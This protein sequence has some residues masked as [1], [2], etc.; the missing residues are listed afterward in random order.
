MESSARSRAGEIGEDILIILITAAQLIFLTYFHRYISWPITGPGGSVT[1]LSMLTEGYFTWLPFPITASILVI[2][3]CI[4]MIVT[5]SYWFRQAAW[6]VFCIIGVTVTVSLLLIFPFDFSVIPNAA[7]V[8]IVPTAV[9][10]FLILWA[11]M[12][13]V[14]GSVLFVRLRRDR[15]K[16]ESG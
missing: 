6:V 13:A 1:R 8:E 2:V 16:Q 11:A 14:A 7:A 9:T 5:G 12:Y 3:A 15:A 4:I 10:V